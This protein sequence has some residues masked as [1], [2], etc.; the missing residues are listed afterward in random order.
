LLPTAES[1]L[2]EFIWPTGEHRK[3]TTVGF[4]L[5]RRLLQGNADF[6]SRELLLQKRK[7]AKLS[8]QQMS[9]AMCL[10]AVQTL[11]KATIRIS[12]LSENVVLSRFLCKLFWRDMVEPSDQPSFKGQVQRKPPL[13]KRRRGLARI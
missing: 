11:C 13:G 1:K 5:G 4:E 6:R 12:N 7:F 9:I 2:P 10:K 3:N 8:T